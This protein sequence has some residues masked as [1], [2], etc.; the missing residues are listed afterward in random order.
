MCLWT[1]VTT[2]PVHTRW[3]LW[4]H[5]TGLCLL[6]PRKLCAFWCP[7]P[8]RIGET[9]RPPRTSHYC[10]PPWTNRDILTQA[11]QLPPCRHVD[12][13]LQTQN[14]EADRPLG[15]NLNSSFGFQVSLLRGL[16]SKTSIWGFPEAPNRTPLMG[17]WEASFWEQCQTLRV[18]ESCRVPEP[19]PHSEVSMATSTHYDPSSGE[20]IST[21]PSG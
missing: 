21:Q 17:T 10:T 7:Q 2:A 8:Y 1:S 13:C 20:S 11:E 12:R 5:T 18:G 15:P 16:G 19:P 4:R 9:S 6:S 3:G 14:I